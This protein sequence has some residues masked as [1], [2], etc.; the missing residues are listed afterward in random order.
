MTWL[1]QFAATLTGRLSIVGVGLA[2]LFAVYKATEYKGIQKER[3]RVNR[4]AAKTDGQARTARSN[5]LR[6]PDGVLKRY[7]RD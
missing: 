2:S 5:A 7:Y 1:I 3:E 6:D 4:E